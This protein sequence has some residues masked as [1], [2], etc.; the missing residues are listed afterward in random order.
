MEDGL[1]EYTFRGVQAARNGFLWLSSADGLNRYDGSHIKVYKNIPGDSLSLADN[2]IEAVTEDNLGNIWLGGHTGKICYMDP[3]TELFHRVR[4]GGTAQIVRMSSDTKGNVW[5]ATAGQGMFRFWFDENGSL[6]QKQYLPNIYITGFS[7]DG[8]ILYV[9]TKSGEI[10][11]LDYAVPN[12]ETELLVQRDDAFLSVLK[13]GEDLIISS[14]AHLYRYN[15]KE[16]QLYFLW[17]NM[18][19]CLVYEETLKDHYFVG[20]RDGLYLYEK[21]GNTQVAAY[22][23]SKNPHQGL[24]DQS[25]LD[26]SI[27]N[28][29]H[30]VVGTVHLVTL[31]DF[32][33]PYVK[34]YSKDRL[35]QRILPSNGHYGFFK[36]G[37]DLWFGLTDGLCLVRDGKVYDFSDFVDSSSK[38]VIRIYK[39]HNK[40]EIWF[41]T[42]EGKLKIDL[43]TFDP[44]QPEF[45]KIKDARPGPLMQERNFVRDMVHDHNGQ[46]WGVTHGSGTFRREDLPDGSHNYYRFGYDAQNP[47]SIQSSI[48]QKVVPD[49]Q[50]NLWFATDSG[51]SMLSHDQLRSTNPRFINYSPIEGQQDQLPHGI[52]YTIFF[53]SKERMWVGTQQGLALYLGEGKFKSWQ[54][55]D[56][57]PNDL[58][59]SIE[60]DAE[61]MLWIGT[62][63]GIVRFDPNTETFVHYGLSDGL[64]GLAFEHQLSHK[65]PD[66]T[67]Y[68]GGA[69][70][71]SYFHPEDLKK[72]DTPVPLYFTNLRV[73][74]EDLQPQKGY[75]KILGQSLF[76]T[77]ELEIA[78]NQFPFRL[79]FSSIDHRF[80]KQVGY[81][82][83]LLPQTTEWTQLEDPEIPFVNLP[84][85]DYTLE[86]NGF[87]RGKM[88]EQEPLTMSM[89]I[90]PPWWASRMAYITYLLLALLLG[91]W[92]Y[93]FQLSRKL[94]VAESDRLKDMDHL[95][96]SLYTNITHEFRTP[97]TVISGMVERIRD[98]FHEELPDQVDQSLEMIDRNGNQLLGLVN[99]MLDLAKLDAQSLEVE[100]V[101]ADIIP[102]I[103]YLIEGFQSLAENK[104]IRLV[105]YLEDDS[106]MMDFDPKKMGS[107]L[108]NLLSNAI[109]YTPNEGEVLV[110]VHKTMVGE[111]SLLEIKVR[112]SGIGIA[113]DRLS[114]IFD[115]FYQVHDAR[116]KN[117]GGTGIGLA[118]CKELCQ[119]LGGDISAKSQKNKGSEFR[120]RLPIHHNAETET[121][122]LLIPGTAKKKALLMPLLQQKQQELPL[123][124]I[125]EDNEDVAHY[126]Q[127][128][129]FTQ[130]QCLYAPDGEQGIEMALEHMPD[131]V[132]SDVMMPKRDGFELCETLKNDPRTDHIPIVL[133]TAKA[134]QN[135]R[136]TGLGHGADAYL[137]KPF[138]KVELFTRLEQLI[139][140][141]KK[142]LDKMDHKGYASLLRV[143]SKDPK[144][145]FIK[146]VVEQIHKNMDNSKFGS[147]HLSRAV[148]LSESQ[149]YRKLKAITGKSTAIFI[150]SIRLQHAKTVL[151]HGDKN[152]S[153]VAYDCGFNN[154][155]WFSKAFKEEF[156]Y[157]PSELQQSV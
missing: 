93:K 58:V 73:K 131:I 22:P 1:S 119:I 77:S 126:L 141:R 83:R 69:F 17:E 154:P 135:D 148:L 84:A 21:E 125:V 37:G 44:E 15:L 63:G 107:I 9:S 12:S 104:Q 145:E 96:T 97:L 101:Q 42:I 114:H 40:A 143:K 70:G 39:D 134:T 64:Q 41:L 49:A 128:C 10:Y 75:Q 82:Y 133:L 132:I 76:H 142:M 110:H 157:P 34:N 144:T 91:F 146:S 118:L 28:Q 19:R 23:N 138:S 25:K 55:Q 52:G 50:G 3:K 20:N 68:F 29:D 129:L 48:I 33:E 30:I 108:T 88:W 99:D 80:N 113:P 90:L 26:I 81:R 95:K 61:G 72:A 124:L 130:Y 147:L 2:F 94:A 155:S 24:S 45:D 62:N 4:Y 87:S 5:V 117:T 102:Y 122:E 56:Q 123:A 150:R 153:E 89:A 151:Q 120:F 100:W 115:R 111:Q 71:V 116:L 36:D 109:K 140:L 103:K 106:L 35:G 59:Y 14:F 8:D 136:L 53:D 47:H 105:T 60:E 139:L 74:N 57:F 46:V 31:I 137:I 11:Q 65:D 98:N 6:N 78:H 54:A 86:I 67:L 112:D 79:D 43:K 13:N 51:V 16:K 85:G 32:S 149:L 92:F 121:L 127:G 38:S 18:G 27:I 66:G 152:V 156:G 7:R